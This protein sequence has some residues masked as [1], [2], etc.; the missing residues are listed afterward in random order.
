MKVLHVIHKLNPGGIETWLKDLAI[1]NEKVKSHDIFILTQT[2]E[3]AFYDEICCCLDN[4]HLVKMEKPGRFFAYTK[5]LYSYMVNKD[6]DVVHSHTGLFSGWIAF[7]AYLARVKVRVV[8]VHTDKIDLTSNVK[9]TY[10]FIMKRFMHMFSSHKIAVSNNANL[11][12][13]LSDK[14]THIIPCGINFV[15]NPTYLSKEKLGFKV[16]DVV[17]C[18]VGRFNKVKNHIFLID[19]V[20]SLPEKYKLLLVGDGVESISIQK[21]V[22]DRGL[23]AR[24][25]F[26]GQRS[27]VPSIL[28]HVADLF[29]LPSHFEG[30]GL[31]A[32]EAQHYGVKTLVS[33]KVPETVNISNYCY[34]LPIS[35]PLEWKQFV[36]KFTDKNNHY[37]SAKKACDNNAYSICDNVAKIN[38]I[39]IN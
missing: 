21:L 25:I 15:E 33:N 37:S 8:H 6:F 11:Q 17:L 1:Y 18:H 3:K 19:L 38:N 30:F 39:Y 12:F 2:K 29:L 26:L 16:D 24:V 13:F 23:Q 4:T 35:D 31:A 32:V 9:K 27:D 36:L 20:F 22:K 10:A 34:F 7:V 14:N 28:K 5:Q